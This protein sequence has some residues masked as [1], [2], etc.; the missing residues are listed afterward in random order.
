VIEEIGIQ[1]QMNGS[2]SGGHQFLELTDIG[3]MVKAAATAEVTVDF[4]ILLVDN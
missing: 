1:G 3:W 4:E 2:F